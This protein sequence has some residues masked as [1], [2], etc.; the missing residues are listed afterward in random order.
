[1]AKYCENRHRIARQLEIRAKK[2][3][4]RCQS[5]FGAGALK[6]RF[7]TASLLHHLLISKNIYTNG[8]STMAARWDTIEN[9]F[10]ATMALP[11]IDDSVADY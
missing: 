4:C 5:Q 7:Q 1:M 2:R 6:Q 8:Y 3:P 11:I 10:I 9:R